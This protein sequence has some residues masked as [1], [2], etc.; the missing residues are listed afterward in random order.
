VLFVSHNLTAVQQLCSRSMLLA[1]G[2]LIAEGSTEE[3]V[4][5]YLAG[6]SSGEDET[7]LHDR[8]DREGSGR[9]RFTSIA[10]ES[11]G[12]RTDT[13]V[14]GRELDI[15]LNYEIGGGKPVREPI[16]AI[17]V[18]TLLGNLILQ[19]QS[20][21]AG[22]RFR[23]VA[24]HGQIRV[25]LPRLALPAGRYTLNLFA[26]AGNEIA[27]W[28]QRATELTVAEGDF[29]MSGEPLPESHQSVLVDQQWLTAPES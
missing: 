13:P 14:T 5:R 25:R 27:D 16:F 1:G 15:I 21:V 12:E 17:G 19:L 11:E 6:L 10:Y 7:P 9:I 22:A 3:V 4:R 8:A 28:L 23:E 18:Y 2:R 26:Y 24:D 20:N 29:Y